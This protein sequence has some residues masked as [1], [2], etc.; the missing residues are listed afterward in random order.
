[1]R[2]QNKQKPF[3]STRAEY[4]VESAKSET[5]FYIYD[6]IG[7]FGIS[8]QQFA[9]DI[10]K[11]KGGTIN[12]RIN[13]PGGSVFDGMAIFNA[14]KQHKTK[15][16]VYIDGIAAS[17]AS[18]IALAGDEVVMA[19]NAFMMIHEPGSLVL[20]SAD[21]LRKE[22][23]LLD[24]LTGSLVKTYMT[25]SGKDDDEIRELMADETW[26]NAAEALAIGFVDSIY[27]AAEV[28]EEAK[29]LFDLSIFG[30]VPEALTMKKEEL[31]PRDLEKVLRDAGV[32]K[33]NAKTIL[34]GGLG[35]VSGRDDPEPAP[36]NPRRDAA[37]AT[38]DDPLVVKGST[39]ELLSRM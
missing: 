20:G 14:I 16:V 37:N 18:V 22:A 23:D 12:I 7:W 34:A 3:P 39:E 15:T 9:E 25:A 33:K 2:F 27:D 21:D 4:R 35:A 24:K 32:S 10:G 26:F 19:D 11:V 17:I 13:S 8:A 29:A 38:I 30:N 36:E 31:N 28:E 6:E 5:T 1:M